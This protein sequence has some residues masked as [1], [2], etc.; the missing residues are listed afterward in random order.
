MF[1]MKK[2]FTRFSFACLLVLSSLFGGLTHFTPVFANTDPN[3]P[4]P[5][6]LIDLIL[7]LDPETPTDPNQPGNKTNP[8][9]PST[10]DPNA[11]LPDDVI[12]DILNA[13]G[14]IN[15]PNAPSPMMSSTT[16]LTP[17]KRTRTKTTPMQTPI[18]P[19]LAK[20]KA[21]VYPGSSVLRLA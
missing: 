12:D 1:I 3:E 4:L 15:D 2:L 10:N 16:F 14:A 8:P 7:G 20:I 6:E 11:P 9:V 5:D 19:T 13:G 18:I 21:R 17:G